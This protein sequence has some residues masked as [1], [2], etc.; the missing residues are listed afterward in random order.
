MPMPFPDHAVLLKATEQ[1]GRRETAM[2][3]RSLEK[4]GMVTAWHGKCESDTA[5]QCKSNGKDTF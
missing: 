2:L 5:A 3:C 1:N 4:N